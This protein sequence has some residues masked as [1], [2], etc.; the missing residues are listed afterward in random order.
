M[1]VRH[2][3]SCATVEEESFHKQYLVTYHGLVNFLQ[4]SAHDLEGG[5]DPLVLFFPHK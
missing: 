1:T 2:S 4:E 5:R 3:M